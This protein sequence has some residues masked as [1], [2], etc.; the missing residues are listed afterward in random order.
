MAGT[1]R[2]LAERLGSDRLRFPLALAVGAVLWGLSLPPY[3]VGI[4]AV[5]AFVPALLF[6][7]EETPRRAASWGWAGGALC[8]AATLWWLVPT[9]VR[10]G[11]ISPWMAIP[12]VAGLAVLLG[13]YWAGFFGT[14]AWAVR[15][16]GEGALLLAPCAW[17][18]WEWMRGHLLTGFPWWG[19]GY[20]LSLYPALL[21]N[22]RFFGI[23]GLSFLSVLGASAVALWVRERG[24][25]TTLAA[26]LLSVL[27][28]GGAFA[29]GTIQEGRPVSPMPRLAVG[30]LQP[31]IRQD[32]KWD[33]LEAERTWQKMETLSLAF[34]KFGLRLLVWPESCTPMAWDGDGAYRERV[35]ALARDLSAPVLLGTTFGGHGGY[36][37]GAVLVRPD[38]GEGGR[39]AKTHLVPFGEYVPLRRLLFFARPLVEAVG[40]FVPGESLTPVSTPAGAASVT[41]CYEAIFPGLVR[42]QVRE[43]GEILVN[44]TNDAWYEGT[45]GPAQHFLM[46]RVRAVETDRFLIRSA[47]GG[48]SGIV[49]P[50]GRLQSA[51]TPGE[52]AS[53]WGIVAPRTTTTL[54]VGIGEGWLVLPLF[55]LFLAILPWP[56]ERTEPGQSPS[57]ET[58]AE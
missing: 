49:D 3:G 14:L 56:K 43:G 47:N 40:D 45:P 4:L 25:R 33:P 18:I 20:S 50:R 30:Y 23:L 8:E 21:Q 55:L 57:V 41:I 6:L 26:I 27:L 2:R 37:N 9:M 10:Y 16:R 51:A 36:Q 58:G 1:V 42:R 29:W 15:R 19:P 39:Y 7:P 34:R 32:E 35:A 48:I 12:L 11:G 13:L 31:Q 22:T 28:Y 46:E 24:A 17:V 5:A 38:G 53:F 54:W 52:P 44:L